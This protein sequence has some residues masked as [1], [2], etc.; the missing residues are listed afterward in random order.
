MS[1]TDA[2][3]KATTWT[4]KLPVSQLRAKASSA[5]ADIIRNTKSRVSISIA[6]R[7][8]MAVNQ[9]SHAFSASHS[10][11]I[12]PGLSCVSATASSP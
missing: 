6:A 11:M 5:A 12:D 3:A 10:H 9:N 7:T 1:S 2:R 4:T 8:I